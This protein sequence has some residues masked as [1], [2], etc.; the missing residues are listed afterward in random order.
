MKLK[1]SGRW[2]WKARAESGREFDGG[3]VLINGS[4]SGQEQ[5]SGI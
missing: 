4:P 5:M 3:D 1:A 2:E